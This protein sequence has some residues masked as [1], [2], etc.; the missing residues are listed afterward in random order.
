MGKLLDPQ[1]E[2]SV[3]HGLDHKCRPLKAHVLKA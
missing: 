1:N 3:C 2:L